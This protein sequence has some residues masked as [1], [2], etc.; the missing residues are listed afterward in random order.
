[1]YKHLRPVKI[2]R[3]GKS[4][5][6]L[7]I[8]RMVKILAVAENQADWK[9]L[10][11]AEN[12]A[13]GKILAAAENQA[14]GKI[15][16]ARENQADWEILAGVEI[17]TP[18]EILAEQEK[19]AA[20]LLFRLGGISNCSLFFLP[21]PADE[22]VLVLLDVMNLACSLQVRKELRLPCFYGRTLSRTVPAVCTGPPCQEMAQIH[23]ATKSL[24]SAWNSNDFCQITIIPNSAYKRPITEL[25]KRM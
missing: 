22:H 3:I 17:S 10:A 9:I 12:Q 20:R 18:S 2:R 8:R 7:K 6:L 4:L 16:A 23:A 25:K 11:V 24:A 15:L 1:M 19:Q 14:D 21:D 5:R 13:D